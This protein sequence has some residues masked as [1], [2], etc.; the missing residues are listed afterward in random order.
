MGMGVVA[1]NHARSVLAT[2]CDTRPHIRDPTSVEALAMWQMVEFCV[3]MG[4]W[5]IIL[6]GDALEIIQHLRR[7]EDWWGSYGLV[8]T[9]CKTEFEQL[10]GTREANELCLINF[11]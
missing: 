8:G 11:C 4:W 6:E 10:R 7:M 3:K 1:C 2:Y 9:R 5:K